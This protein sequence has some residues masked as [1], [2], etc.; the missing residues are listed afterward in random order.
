M[1]Y[2]DESGSAVKDS[3][4]RKNQLVKQIWFENE[5]SLDKNMISYCRTD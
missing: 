1:Y 5:I 4:N 2:D 3:S